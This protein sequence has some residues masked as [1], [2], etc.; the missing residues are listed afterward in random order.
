MDNILLGIAA[1]AKV[2]V[3]S[4]GW[5]ARGRNRKMRK[6]ALRLSLH[7]RRAKNTHKGTMLRGFP[8]RSNG[9][10]F[11]CDLGDRDQALGQEDPL[12]K[13]M[14]THSDILP[15]RILWTEESGSPWIC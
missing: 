15:W 1:V 2:L 10:E 11:A 9:K 4:Q 13:E 14:A 12:E 7:P 3:E 8:G 5:W 6:M